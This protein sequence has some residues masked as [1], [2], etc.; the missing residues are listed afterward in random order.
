[1]TKNK[2]INFFII[3]IF[4]LL[5]NINVDNSSRIKKRLQKKTS[6]WRS[7]GLDVKV[8]YALAQTNPPAVFMIPRTTLEIEPVLTPVALS[9]SDIEL[10]FLILLPLGV[11]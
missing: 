9:A 1:M 7:S 8:I 10:Y 6:F 3:F 4:K 2:A 5:D 11:N